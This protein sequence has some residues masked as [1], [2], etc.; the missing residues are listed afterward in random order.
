MNGITEVWPSITV[1]KARAIKESLLRMGEPG[2]DSDSMNM[3]QSAS[4]ALVDSIIA[5]VEQ[6][7]KDIM[8]AERER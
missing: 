3:E 5:D 1:L 6:L 7:H 8:H 2:Q 4:L